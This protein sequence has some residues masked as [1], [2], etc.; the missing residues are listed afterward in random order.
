MVVKRVCD[1]RS[2][3]L[4]HISNDELYAYFENE[5]FL[6]TYAIYKYY[7]TFK[8][9]NQKYFLDSFGN[10]TLKPIKDSQMNKLSVKYAVP[11]WAKGQIMYHIFVDRFYR[12]SKKNLETMAR[13]HI[14]NSWDEDVVVNVDGD[15]IPNND[16]YG[17]DLLGII[18]KLE[19]IKSLGTGIIYL[20]PVF[21]SQST[22][23]YDTSNYEMIDP[24][25]GTNEDLKL[26]CQKAHSMGM[27]IILD[28]VF[29]HTGSDS[30]YFNKFNS[31]DSLGAYQSLDSKYLPF[32]K[33]K[34]VNGQPQF[35]YWWGFDNLPE[36]NCDGLEWQSYIVAPGGIIDKWFSMGIDGLRLDVPDVYSDSFNELIRQAVLRNKKDGLIIGEIWYNPIRC[37]RNFLA[38]G[39]AMDSVMNYNLAISLINYFRHGSA[40]ELATK[41][42]ELIN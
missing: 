21:Y 37:G 25:A 7:F 5:I 39:K 13:R 31:F 15:G 36:C 24:Y 32:Y 30:I 34:M 33:Y 35:S 18:D 38:G 8:V 12:G 4:K 10:I 22:H 27:K 17:G 3:T 9:N 28:A 16:F 20:S 6:D 42:N 41:I 11:D 26:L 23:R 2:F 1:E 40:G 19:Y 29:N 14:H